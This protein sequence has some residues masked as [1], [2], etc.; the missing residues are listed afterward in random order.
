MIPKHRKKAANAVA[1]LRTWQL[2]VKDW[3]TITRKA[4][5][6]RDGTQCFYCDYP[7]TEEFPPTLEHLLPVSAGGTDHISNIVLACDPCNKAVG[8]WPLLRKI[9]YR[10][11]KHR[12]KL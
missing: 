5:R 4:V 1:K 6:K 11:F 3:K 8:N 2:S 9:K 10:E 12:S 7:F